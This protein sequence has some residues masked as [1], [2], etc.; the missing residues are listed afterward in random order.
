METKVYNGFT[1]QRSA[2]G[3]PW[4]LVGP[5]SAPA[6]Q[7][8]MPM[9][10]VTKRADPAAAI[11]LP[12]AQAELASTQASTEAAR[13]RLA[14]APYDA[15]KAAADATR[16]ELEVKKAK[17]DAEAKPKASPEQ[18]K[19][20]GDL[21]NDEVL[22]A[23][24]RARKGISGGWSTGRVARWPE[25][26]RPQAA[27]DL[28]GD[29]GT[30]SSR[31]TL[32]TLAKLKELSATGASGLG[33]LS[34][35]EG[36]MLRDSVSALDQGQSADKLL[37]SLANVEKHYRAVKA[38]QDGK[39]FRD[40][41]V[42]QQYGLAPMPAQGDQ[43][44]LAQGGAR[45]E[46]DP[47]LAGVNS[48]IRG[49]IG[50]GKS[51]G[52]I[53]AYAN[54]VQSGLGD[55]MAGDLGQAVQFRA[56][57][58]T[59]PLSKY[60]V[61]VEN[62][63]V[64]MSGLRQ[65]IN[66]AAQSPFGAYMASATDALSA[67]T[68]DNL[69]ENPALAR[70]GMKAISENNP[71]SSIAGML[72]GGALAGALTEGAV[73][74]AGASLAPR[75]ADLLYGSAYGAGS[76][77]EG[78]RLEGAGWGAVGGIAGGEIGRRGMSAI[79]SGLRGVQNEGA[80]VLR[81]RDIPLT[82]GQML[83]GASKTREDRLAGFGGVG[84]KINARRRGGIREFNRAAFDEGVAPLGEVRLGQVGE[85]GVSAMR[86][87][88][89]GSGGAY[90]QALNGVSLVP[91]QP[92]ASSVAAALAQGSSLP[93]V[94]PEFGAFVDRSI[95]P[96][97]DA[98]N[99]QIDGRQVQDI[100]QQVR[101][102]DFGTDSMGNLASGSA[103]DIEG[104]VM[105][106]AGRQAPGSMEALGN[107]N[108]AYRNLNILADATGKGMNT[109]GIFTPAQLGAASRA[110]T[111]KFGGRIAAATP[112]RPFF[113]LQRAGQ[114]VLP[115]Q[116][117]DSGTAGRVE[118]NGGIGAA[119]RSA[120]RNTVNAPLYAEGTQETI[121]RLL[122]DRTPAMVQAGAALSE[123]ARIAALLSR[124]ASLAYGP[125]AVTPEY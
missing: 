43:L 48:H 60:A 31:V 13:A 80:R 123:R 38:I 64:P 66:S 59:V 12:K 89:S 85:D 91:D 20:M 6:A 72:T 22:A 37:D 104:A 19:A 78:S 63:S 100:L 53:A 47:A 106:L 105:D 3:E 46:A 99:G 125:L 54:S 5:A 16:A 27:F 113:E 118:A 88:V 116:I 87:A 26:V 121:A 82:I 29:L 24:D 79:G 41:M 55:K 11:A 73:G 94:G 76:A 83:G 95:A 33:A 111:T 42:A 49:M 98:P 68:I 45:D 40:P 7:S 70:A 28:K 102:A 119:V 97:F 2:P 52:Q 14:T 18:V 96:H 36:D 17:I 69:Q 4:A 23:I 124:P 93:R 30:I 122:M 57:N 62:R 50:A 21:A 15:R 1:Y 103:R 44:A 51:A 77:D 86:Q 34:E 120:V 67:G 61:S 108:T 84:D 71:V 9:S 65:T 114:D 92:F 81:D 90:D 117:P 25:M 35:R 115:S 75:I 112:D 74:R 107:A 58:P 101:G 39:D 56:Q 109:G 32:D 8:A 110:N 10:V